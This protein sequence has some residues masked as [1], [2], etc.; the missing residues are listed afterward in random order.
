MKKQACK[1]ISII[2]GS[3]YGI[4][5]AVQ[6][7]K[8]LRNKVEI[9]IHE[10]GNQILQSWNEQDINGI[11]ITNGFHGIE[12]PRSLN[13]SKILGNEFIDEN[14]KKIANYKLI[15][16]N[17]RLVP[18]RYDIGLLPDNIRNELEGLKNDSD[19]KDYLKYGNTGELGDLLK[20][21]GRRY[22]NGIEDYFHMI[23]PW[24]FPNKF[25]RED[26]LLSSQTRKKQE[27]YYLI[28]KDGTFVKARKNLEE[29]LKELG[30]KVETNSQIDIEEKMDGEINIWATNTAILAKRYLGRDVECL[31]HNKRNLTV[32][33]F[34]IKSEELRRTMSIFEY[35]PS[36]ILV[37]DKEDIDLARISFMDIK[38]D[39]RK[40]YVILESQSDSKKIIEEEEIKK[41]SEKI[42][43]SELEYIG[44]K[45]IGTLYNAGMNNYETIEKKFEEIEKRI[46]VKVGFK[47]WWPIN[48]CRAADAAVQYSREIIEEIKEKDER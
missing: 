40:K 4:L 26:R 3:L 36:E 13:F 23:F 8:Q 27:S 44:S 37:M 15:W 30:I 41:I 7:K 38:N 10:K 19:V 6:I 24:Y 21:V 42:L 12:I 48:S 35:R 47:Y 22:A 11:K 33:L 32:S 14:F 2:G 31:R 46:D 45:E 34:K 28:P 20:R 18:Y 5:L 25:F 29:Y 9:V 39:S 1:K 43:S 17:D 16:L